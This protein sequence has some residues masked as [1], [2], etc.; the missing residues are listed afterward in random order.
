MTFE[1]FSEIKTSLGILLKFYPIVRVWD[2]GYTKILYELDSCEISVEESVPFINLHTSEFSIRERGSI[3]EA[4]IRIPVIM[5]GQSCY[6]ELVQQT[7]KNRCS[8][9]LRYMQRLVITDSLTGLY[10][11]R[12][13]DEQLP[14]DLNRAFQNS[15]P[16]SFIY[17]DI[18]FFKKI[19]DQ[20][21]HT[22]GDH[23][24]KETA[25]VFLDLVRK[26]GWT[27]RYGGD[28]FLACLPEIT[29]SDAYK[30]ADRIRY[31]IANKPF[32]INDKA[33]EITCSFGVH[34]VSM[35]DHISTVNQVVELLDKKLY[36]AKNEGKNTVAI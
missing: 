30:I 8:S 32:L 12:Y 17:A 26:D 11:R 15:N 4:L 31:A 25:D 35:Y 10:N 1:N 23:I 13:I 6:L 20:Y 27:A 34:T 21:G 16:V 19:N 5:G 36:Q 18:D 28:E 7:S 2:E 3:L 24:L 29:C 22:A 33:L 9:S 14:L